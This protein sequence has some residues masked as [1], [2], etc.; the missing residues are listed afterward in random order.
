MDFDLS[1]FKAGDM[2]EKPD[3]SFIMAPK[4]L[5]ER[6]LAPKEKNKARASSL[7]GGSTSIRP[8][9]RVRQYQCRVQA[10]A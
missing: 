8:K 1:A 2:A 10:Y 4:Y 6:T 3:V 9:T 7:D 5:G